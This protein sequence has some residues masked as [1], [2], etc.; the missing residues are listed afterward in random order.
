M[1]TFPKYIILCRKEYHYFG[2]WVK[3]C[4]NDEQLRKH[5]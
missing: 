3:I 1:K 4:N 5:Q 2:I